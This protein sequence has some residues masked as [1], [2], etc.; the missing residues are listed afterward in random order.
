MPNLYLPKN[1]KTWRIQYYNREL[2][3]QTSRSCRTKDKSIANKVFKEFR[4]KYE[5][6]M[7]NEQFSLNNETLDEALEM[8]LCEKQRTYKTKKAYALAVFHLKKA[9][10]NKAI[11]KIVKH[12]YFS[13]LNH[14]NNYININPE[15]EKLT[16]SL[17][18]NTIANYTRHIYALMKWMAGNKMIAEN[19]FKVQKSEKVTV[20]VIEKIDLDKI[21]DELKKTKYEEIFRL[22]YLLALRATEIANLKRSDINFGEKSISIQ[23]DK[24]KRKDVLPMIDE[25]EIILK[26]RLEAD[27]EYLY[28]VTYDALKSAWGRVMRKLEFDYSIHDLRRTRGTELAEKGVNPFYVKEYMRHTSLKTTEQYYIKINREKMRAEIETKEAKLFILNADGAVK[29]A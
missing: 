28:P 10:G 16:K 18:V 11:K 22:I 13:F 5:L 9:I 12:D 27:G 26:N 7:I 19:Y 29:T 2:G 1:S 8:F 21:F 24:G 23:N 20:T 14:L 6:R 15:N 4:A 3:I 25:V 17:A